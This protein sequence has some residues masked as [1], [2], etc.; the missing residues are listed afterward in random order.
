MDELAVGLGDVAVEKGAALPKGNAGDLRDKV[1]H[2][3]GN[4]GEGR[5]EAFRG[6]V[7]RIRTRFI[8]GGFDDGVERTVD[9]FAAIDGLVNQLQRR[10]LSAANQGSERGGIVVEKGHRPGSNAYSACAR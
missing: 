7:S 6:E 8:K 10:Y 5:P 3:K 4:P 1:L 2:Q 9:A